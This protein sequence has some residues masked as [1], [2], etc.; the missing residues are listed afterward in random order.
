[1]TSSGEASRAASALASGSSARQR[2]WCRASSISSIDCA[3]LPEI[4]WL[5]A[6]F[7]GHSVY[8]KAGLNRREPM[9]GAAGVLD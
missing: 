7:I 4:S 3:L 5:L 8:R 9:V 2:N 6:S 1:M